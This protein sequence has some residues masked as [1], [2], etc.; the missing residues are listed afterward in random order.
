VMA[1]WRTNVRNEL[2]GVQRMRSSIEIEFEAVGQPAA[3]TSF[4]SDI[5][6]LTVPRV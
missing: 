6:D 3:A 2:R 5:H 1:E 4:L